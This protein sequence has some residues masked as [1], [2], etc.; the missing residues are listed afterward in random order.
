MPERVKRVLLPAMAASALF[1]A[2]GH[3]AEPVV[4]RMLPVDCSRNG[5]AIDSSAE[6]SLPDELRLLAGLATPALNSVTLLGGQGPA[7]NDSYAG[8]ERSGVAVR[9]GYRM[10]SL[11][12]ALKGPRD[13]VCSDA[14]ELQVSFRQQ[15]DRKGTEL[16]R[17]VLDRNSNNGSLSDAERNAVL[18]AV[19]EKYKRDLLLFLGADFP[20]ARKDGADAERKWALCSVLC[21]VNPERLLSEDPSG[22]RLRDWPRED[23]RFSV[24]DGTPRMYLRFQPREIDE[25]Y[26]YM[27][28]VF[29]ADSWGDFVFVFAAG[30]DGI[31]LQELGSPVADYYETVPKK[32]SK[33]RYFSD[34]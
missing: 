21:Y 27:Q 15:R 18:D 23:L 8:L 13:V 7:A 33:H 17:L 4:H 11:H 31:D 1:V 20:W 29:L 30:H 22:S 2:P 5:A 3:A 26:R 19:Q 25:T 32:L 12:L 9:V 6:I 10:Q 16:F 24:V 28:W 34:D 14:F